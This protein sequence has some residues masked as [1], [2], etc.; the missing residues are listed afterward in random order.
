[1]NEG[2]N[3]VQLPQ[4]FSSPCTLSKNVVSPQGR[5]MALEGTGFLP[6]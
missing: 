1:M 2:V 3:D 5:G 4:D 6:H